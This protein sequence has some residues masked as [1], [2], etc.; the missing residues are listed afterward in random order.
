LRQ[1]FLVVEVQLWLIYQQFYVKEARSAAGP[2]RPL[3]QLY[4]HIW[5]AGLKPKVP[6]R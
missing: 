3:P 4:R 1:V 6:K 5:G 2:G